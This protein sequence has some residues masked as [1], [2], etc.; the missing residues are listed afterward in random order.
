MKKII[1]THKKIISV[2]LPY[3]KS[4][5]I[6]SIAIAM[7][8]LKFN[9]S[10]NTFTIN[11]ITFS[12]DIITAI[13]IAKALGF[14]V[15]TSINSISL[16]YNEDLFINDVVFDCNESALCYRLFASVGQLFASNIILNASGTL[17]ERIKNYCCSKLFAGE[18]IL[19]CSDTSQILTGLLY[20]LPFLDN[21]SIIKIYH[22]VSQKYIDMSI[23]LLRKAGIIIGYENNIISIKGHQQVNINTLHIEGDWSAAANFFVLGAIAGQTLIHNI[24]IKSKQPDIAILRLF[25]SLNIAVSQV[26]SSTFY[27]NKSQYMGFE[28]D[29][30]NCPDIIA[31]LVVLAFNAKSLSKI[32][33]INRLINK[34]SNRKDVLIKVFTMLGGR[35]RIVDD[36]FEI[37]PSKLSGGFADSHND[38]RIA[39][40]IAVAAKICKNPIILTGAES[41]NKSFSDFWKYFA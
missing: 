8:A 24:S 7:T 34:E 16:E 2:I 26:D 21:N 17:K 41:V 1:Y 4:L 9:R 18:Y 31:P 19:D 3:S 20:S 6:R 32:T 13:N 38:H 23:D 27:V 12:D 22:L 36:S 15:S 37:H 29:I 39:M 10:I 30:T 25:K 28:F 40:A 35:I 33:G 5:T 14:N 11:N